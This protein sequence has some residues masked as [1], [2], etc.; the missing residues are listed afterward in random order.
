MDSITGNKELNSISEIICVNDASTDDSSSIINEYIKGHDNVRLIEFKDN[1]GPGM[2]RNKGIEESTGKYVCFIDGDDYID[3][4]IYLDLYHH[5]NLYD[6]DY[7]GCNVKSLVEN[8]F[9]EVPLNFLRTL[10]IPEELVNEEILSYPSLTLG[11]ICMPYIYNKQIFE[12]YDLWFE[13]GLYEDILF[14][15]TLHSLNL[16][17]GFINEGGYVYVVTP[18]SI[19]S[20]DYLFRNQK[21]KMENYSL[22]I[23]YLN[24]EG[25]EDMLLYQIIVF[26]SAILLK[27][28]KTFEDFKDLMGWIVPW[29]SDSL[30]NKLPTLYQE[31]C[32]CI[33]Y[34]DEGLYELF[35][36]CLKY[37]QYVQFNSKTEL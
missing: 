25:Y 24:D 32:F 20:Y 19:T 18:K 10:N 16:D 22:I 9:F 14:I 23:Q 4:K 35:K 31:L 2:A 7:V 8:K 3:P 13:E 33:K 17:F 12:D 15:H 36:E 37:G 34:E 6:E 26:E 11:N 28:T 30:L 1:K 21:M 5:I 29:L 27:N